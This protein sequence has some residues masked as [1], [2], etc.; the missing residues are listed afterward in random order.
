MIDPVA[1]QDR[2]DGV[3]EL[4]MLDFALRIARD[5]PVEIAL[6]PGDEPV[7]AGDIERTTLRMLASSA[8]W[9]DAIGAGHPPERRASAS[10]S[11]T[12][13]SL[14]HITSAHGRMSRQRGIAGL[15]ADSEPG[16]PGTSTSPAIRPRPAR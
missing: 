3:E 11:A 15:R 4:Q 9:L 8:S 5:H 7:E 12:S 14:S 13:L 10:V 1:D 6:G 16:A 2:V